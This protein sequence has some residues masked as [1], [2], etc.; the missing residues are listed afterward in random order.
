[1]LGGGGGGVYDHV[2]AVIDWHGDHTIG[3]LPIARS[4]WELFSTAVSASQRA[5][6][7]PLGPAAERLNICILSVPKG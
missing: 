2:T 1:M 4:V 6:R 3:K 7:Q 5:N